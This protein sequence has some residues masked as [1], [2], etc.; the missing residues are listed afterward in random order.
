MWFSSTLKSTSIKHCLLAAALVFG[1]VA[2]HAVM[3]QQSAADNVVLPSPAAAI[4]SNA[5][6]MGEAT[7]RWF[8]LKLYEC[9]L[10]SEKSPGQF[11]FKT[12]KHYLELVYARNFDGDK[13]AEKSREEIENQGVGKSAQLD[14]WQKKL[15][16]VM[17]NVNKG[18]RL[19][20]L[21]VPG[22]GLSLFKDGQPVG[23]VNEPELA[24]AFMGIWLDPRTSEPAL[25]EK[26]IGLKK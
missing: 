4:M 21:Y 13:I 3:A 18:T 26:L 11:N 9:Q 24:S 25:R 6:K 7:M 14:Q 22:K 20:A 5:K 16:D 1:A 10:W 17:P 8:G 15:T 12:D 19:A 2:P 23:E